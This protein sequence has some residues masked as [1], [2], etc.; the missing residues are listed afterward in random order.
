MYS[1]FDIGQAIEMGRIERGE[2]LLE[3]TLERVSSKL[4]LIDHSI[5]Q[6]IE[7]I[8]LFVASPDELEYESLE[9][10]CLYRSAIE[11]FNELFP[12][13]ADGRYP[14]EP[15]NHEDLEEHLLFRA[16][17]IGPVDPKRI[18]PGIPSSH[19]WWWSWGER[20]E[21]GSVGDPTERR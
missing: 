9:D 6:A 19:W 18:P 11:F 14:W 16:N 5:S 10:G 3:Q 20:P 1:V 17:R 8:E 15:L 21:S 2:P 12:N 4:L 13:P 7:Q